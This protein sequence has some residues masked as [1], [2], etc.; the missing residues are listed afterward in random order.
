MYRNSCYHTTIKHIAANVHDQVLNNL[1]LE[2][3]LLPTRLRE[4]VVSDHVEERNAREKWR[5]S[6]QMFTRSF[7]TNIWL[8]S[9]D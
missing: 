6:R 2:L 4:D 1:Q 7:E 5:F 8:A 9:Y 3:T